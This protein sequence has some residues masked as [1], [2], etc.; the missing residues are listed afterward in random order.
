MSLGVNHVTCSLALTRCGTRGVR[1]VRRSSVW[2]RAA[3][4]QCSVR[5][6]DAD[7]FPHTDDL[8]QSNYVCA[9]RAVLSLLDG[10]VITL[11]Q[12]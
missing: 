1:A 12:S 10:R 9:G 8:W 2:R 5:G 6:G 11:K 4:F 7:A 3:E